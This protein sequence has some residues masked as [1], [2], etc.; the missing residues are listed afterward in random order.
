VQQG[1]QAK[2]YFNDY[3]KISETGSTSGWC[4]GVD[5]SEGKGPCPPL[6][7]RSDGY[8]GSDTSPFPTLKFVSHFVDKGKQGAD[9]KDP[10]DTVMGKESELERIV[11]SVATCRRAL[12]EKEPVVELQV[13]APLETS[14]PVTPSQQ[15]TLG[16]LSEEESAPVLIGTEFIDRK[17]TIDFISQEVTF[18]KNFATIRS[19]QMCPSM[20][21][22]YYEIEILSP[23]CNPQ[24]GFCSP[25]FSPTSPGAGT[26]DCNYSWAVD[27][28]RGHLW[29]NG[30]TTWSV[31]D[32]KPTWNVGDV[33]GLACDLVKG[34]MSVSVNGS[35][36]APY[37]TVFTFSTQ[38]CI[39][40][41]LFASFTANAGKVRYNLGGR[42]PFKFSPPAQTGPEPFQ[43]FSAFPVV[44]IAKS[45]V[46]PVSERSIKRAVRHGAKGSRK[47][48]GQKTA[49][50]SPPMFPALAAGAASFT[51]T[52]AAP[53][54]SSSL[55]L[56]LASTGSAAAERGHAATVPET[57]PIDAAVTPA[58]GAA[59]ELGD[60]TASDE[61][62]PG[63]GAAEPICEDV[64]D[65]HL[66]VALVEADAGAKCIA[67]VSDDGTIALAGN[68][69]L[70]VGDE[71]TLDPAAPAPVAS[72]PPLPF[73]RDAVG[74]ITAIL[75][76]DPVKGVGKMASVAFFSGVSTVPLRDLVRKRQAQTKT[77]RKP[78]DRL[79]FAIS[80]PW[81]GTDMEIA[82]VLNGD[83]VERFGYCP[84]SYATQALEPYARLMAFYADSSN[85]SKGAAA[86]KISQHL[87]IIAGNG[88]AADE[89]S[90]AA[91]LARAKDGHVTPALNGLV[92]W[93]EIFSK[94]SYLKAPYAEREMRREG[95]ALL[96]VDFLRAA[97]LPLLDD[98]ILHEVHKC[99]GELR[100]AGLT[101]SGLNFE[102]FLK[103]AIANKEAF[104]PIFR[105]TNLKQWSQK[106]VSPSCEGS[107]SREVGAGSPS[108][109]VKV[110]VSGGKGSGHYGSV[111]VDEV[112]R[113]AP[114]T[115]QQTLGAA[116]NVASS[117]KAQWLPRC[118][119]VAMDTIAGIVN[120]R[121]GL[122]EIMTYRSSAQT[123][124]VAGWGGAQAS[125]PSDDKLQKLFKAVDETTSLTTSSF[126][127]SSSVTNN[128]TL[129]RS[130]DPHF[131]EWLNYLR[132]M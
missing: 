12:S 124:C 59:G 29:H 62:R 85:D 127:V 98:V 14:P 67:S 49:F 96:V 86:T 82:V 19:R 117:G 119:R 107:E 66:C 99:A 100:V 83:V 44:P 109:N 125:A 45:S 34:Q 54:T 25:E 104:E 75:P 72:T 33:I 110:W 130:L 73:S 26:G 53:R 128:T 18:E 15:H 2:I 118:A 47:S 123:P 38:M 81:D 9:L 17:A 13:I 102:Q 97:S 106:M 16:V 80:R 111:A 129:L 69:L 122:P 27:G 20:K 76:A 58:A 95:L 50:S 70:S 22:A 4:Y 36:A 65:V 3:W 68:P 71:V 115:L 84:S 21:A 93:H 61:H 92:T 116:L 89:E 5:A 114:E 35:F 60:E 94:Y 121:A 132:K 10:P 52:F 112:V 39:N 31:G 11:G 7:W 55:A 37:G 6:A 87:A 41:G 51:S 131:T 74:K 88:V 32:V 126:V 48:T 103:F 57:G 78:G 108:L 120:A 64:P 23:L 30:K 46:I 24:F 43:P 113:V 28:C 63:D 101:S 8:S 91:D 56:D 40:E 90:V 79:G 1:G 105:E 42:S 77:F